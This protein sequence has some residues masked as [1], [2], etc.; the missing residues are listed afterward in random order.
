M[1]LREGSSPLTV[2]NCAKY[3]EIVKVIMDGA[4]SAY[5]AAE[6]KVKACLEAKMA[7]LL[8][9]VAEQTSAA[10]RD[11]IDVELVQ[12]VIRGNR[13]SYVVEYGI[14]ERV[15]FD[16]AAISSS[17]DRSDV[18]AYLLYKQRYGRPD[19]NVD[20][21]SSQGTLDDASDG[22]PTRHD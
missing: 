19:V 4:S 2:A 9:T 22:T 16:T 15:D 11:F 7:A 21:D 8:E 13:Y 5:K 12:S 10:I 14:S 18:R 1:R 6:M 20:G 3:Q 17:I